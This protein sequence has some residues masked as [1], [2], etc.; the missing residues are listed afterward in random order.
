VTQTHY[1]GSLTTNHC[2]DKTHN[3]WFSL[4]DI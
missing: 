2:E 4:S 1:T 3:T